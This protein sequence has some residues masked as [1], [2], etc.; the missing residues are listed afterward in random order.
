MSK[1]GVPLC[2]SA[3]TNSTSIHEHV[4]LIPDPARQ[5]KELALLGA[6]VSVTDEAQTWCC[7]GCGI[8]WQL[9]LR[10]IRALVWE[11][12]YVMHEALKKKIKDK[13]SVKCLFYYPYHCCL[14][15]VY[16]IELTILEG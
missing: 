9:Q 14:P 8:G 12:P 2:G 5:V 4:G 16:T 1:A 6:V 10:L 11:I 13:L 15:L 7:C 3:A